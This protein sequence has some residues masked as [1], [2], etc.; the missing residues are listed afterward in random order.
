MIE[1]SFLFGSKQEAG[2]RLGRLA[3]EIVGKDMPGQYHVLMTPAEYSGYAKRLLI[4]EQWGLEIDVRTPDADRGGGAAPRIH[5]MA[6]PQSTARSRAA[7]KP[8]R[9]R[10]ATRQAAASV[11]RGDS[12]ATSSVEP[13]DEVSQ[14]IAIPGVRAK[15]SKAETSVGTRTAPYL[16]RAFRFCY[17]AAFRAEEITEGLGITDA[18][19]ISRFRS[20]CKALLAVGLFADAGEGRYTVNQA[21]VSRLRAL[22][23]AMKG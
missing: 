13:Q 23:G 4:Y 18:A 16:Q 19:T 17:S 11:G 10:R 5:L 15:M 20:A 3:Y 1:V 2:Q 7:R 8:A 12:P 6:L 21:E 22:A 9:P 14:A